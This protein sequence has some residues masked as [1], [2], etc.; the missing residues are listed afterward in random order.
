MKI[1]QGLLESL[2]K[3]LV[4]SYMQVDINQISGEEICLY[5]KIHF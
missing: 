3:D 5:V 2:L 1:I 4:N